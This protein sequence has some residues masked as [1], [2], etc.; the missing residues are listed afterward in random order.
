M[1][2]FM[3]DISFLHKVQLALTVNYPNEG[4][5]IDPMITIKKVNLWLV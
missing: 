1:N 5:I 2:Y 4:F 3:L